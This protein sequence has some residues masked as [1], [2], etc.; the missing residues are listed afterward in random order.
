MR[1]AFFMHEK[2]NAA[3]LEKGESTQKKGKAY[4]IDVY[5]HYQ[6]IGCEET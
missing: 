2:K 1:K 5:H 6:I 4:L 3:V